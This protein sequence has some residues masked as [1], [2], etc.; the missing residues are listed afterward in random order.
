VHNLG[1]LAIQLISVILLPAKVIYLKC[2]NRSKAFPRCS[3]RLSFKLREVY[4]QLTPSGVLLISSK[5]SE[6]FSTVSQFLTPKNSS[7]SIF[8]PSSF[9]TIYVSSTLSIS[10]SSSFGSSTF[11][12]SVSTTPTSSIKSS[13]LIMTS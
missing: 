5:L 6:I 10:F 13:V 3:R 7:K 11:C 8:S 12:C 2:L 4:T 9:E 1:S